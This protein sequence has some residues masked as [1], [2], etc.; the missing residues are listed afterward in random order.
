LTVS[1][2]TLAVQIHLCNL[3]SKTEMEPELSEEFA[4]VFSNEP[5]E[6]LTY[7]FAC[8]REVSRF[9]PA[10]SDIRELLKAWHRNKAELAAISSRAT[11]KKRLEAA[12]EAGELADPA[13]LISDLVH[14]AQMPKAPS[15][16]E[17]RMKLAIERLRRAD[18]PP[19][20]QLT[21][22]QIAARRDK[23]RE[24]IDRYVRNGNAE[25]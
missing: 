1:Q 23:E 3:N 15:E 8:W 14:I 13:I 18:A 10:I 19:A 25:L 16:R 20:V 21:K 6:A 22:E 12:R 9:I 11:E 5:T 17:Q 7:A 4:R 2:Q 24:E